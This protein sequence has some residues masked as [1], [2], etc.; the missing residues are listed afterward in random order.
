MLELHPSMTVIPELLP[1]TLVKANSLDI[2]Q[3]K[4]DARDLLSV[5]L[6]K[7]KVVVHCTSTFVPVSL[8]V[9]FMQ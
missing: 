7:K 3:V 1:K 6:L 9:S 4:W 5:P 2:M 8:E